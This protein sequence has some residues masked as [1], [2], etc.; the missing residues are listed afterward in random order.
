MRSD[1]CSD[2]A[3]DH[4][5]NGNEDDANADDDVDGDGADCDSDPDGLSKLSKLIG[6]IGNFRSHPAPL[7]DTCDELAAC[8]ASFL[9]PSARLNTLLS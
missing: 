2:A 9:P 6:G 3:C 1:G 5:G 4:G 8:P 7:R